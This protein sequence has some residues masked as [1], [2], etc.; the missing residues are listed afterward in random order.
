MVIKQLLGNLVVHKLFHIAN[1]LFISI[2]ARNQRLALPCPLKICRVA[3]APLP[4]IVEIEHSLHASL[5][6]LNKQIV[7]P[8]QDGVVIHPGLGLQ[9][10]HHMR[11]K[12][13]ATVGAYQYAQV[14]HPKAVKAVELAAQLGAIAAPALRCKNCRIPHVGANIFIRLAVEH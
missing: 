10:R 6:E 13:F 11:S 7:E 12:A 3:A 2:D 1:I 4:R 9:H 8:L 14:V 5:L